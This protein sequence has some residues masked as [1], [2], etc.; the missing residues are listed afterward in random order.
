M[1][2]AQRMVHGLVV[3][4]LVVAMAACG[5]DDSTSD[6]L[7]E[8][9]PTRVPRADTTLDAKPAPGVE[10]TVPAAH[11]AVTSIAEVKSAVVQVITEGSFRDP[12]WGTQGF[13]GSGSGFIVD[14]D[15]LVVTNNHVVTGA[16]VV[17]VRIGGES[18]EIPARIVGVSECN[19]LAVL[20][21]IDPGPYRYLEWHTG[22]ITPPLEVYT[23]GF[24]LG[25]PE[26]TV[27]RG[28]VS[29][30]RADGESSWAS[31]RHVIEH[32]AN[33]QPGNS[34][35]PLVGADGRV[36]GVNYAADDWG[37]GT[38]Q[39]FAISADL[40]A[41]VV[42]RLRGGGDETIGING[43]AGF[44]G[45]VAGVW[46]AGVA[47]GSPA[48]EAGVLPGDVITTL[49]GVTMSAGT[50]ESYCSVLRT[51]NPGAAMSI[52]V[53]RFD[54]SEV[55]EGEVN[56]RPM[57]V[58]FSFADELGD[59]FVDVDPTPIP[60]V[61]A[62]EA[63]DYDWVTDDTGTLTV[64][65]PSQWF[66]RDTSPGEWGYAFDPMPT[67]MAAPD[68]WAFYG[69]TTVP[70]MLFTGSSYGGG[71]VP[72]EEFLRDFAPWTD[73]TWLESWPYTDPVFEGQAESWTCGSDTLFLVVA[74]RRIVNPDAFVVVVVQARS[75][76]DLEALDQILWTFN[77]N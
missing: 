32:D 63:Y 5:G 4:A 36:V 73:C 38:L 47:P 3:T 76:A 22:P 44:E 49:N 24:P 13:V 72:L 7:P 45:D 48:S 34:G 59:E 1:H 8:P 2:P 31:V 27:T 77:F 33:I 50:M 26:Y 10:T 69:S 28:V 64:M 60:G 61:P 71:D 12:I 42:E 25:D 56:G 51:A 41:P 52:Q 20:Q 9:P 30:E 58:R 40:A 65:V 37:T 39:Y 67:I 11:G 74:A 15:G 66:E 57:A 17:K 68:L 70:G 29:K 18:T 23:A 75:T 46:V 14:P 19:D 43:V 54:T 55:W 16:G 21:L 53:F 62:V 6:T 35:G